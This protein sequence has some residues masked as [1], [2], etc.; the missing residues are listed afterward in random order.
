MTTDRPG[1]HAYRKTTT[2][3]R[4]VAGLAGA[5]AAAVAA[6][7]LAQFSFSFGGGGDKSSTPMIDLNKIFD[8]FGAVTL[9]EK[10]EIL[11]GNQLYGKLIDRNGG[12]Y[13][14]RRV[15]SATQRF[16][17]DL[18]K[19]T[20][21]PNLPWEITV[22]DD[23]TINAWALPGGKIA[24]NKGLLR[25]AADEAELAA[26]IS[27]EVGHAELAHGLGMMKTERFSAGFSEVAKGALA[28]ALKDSGGLDNNLVGMMS[29]V[30]MGMVQTGYS[31]EYE[32]EADRHILNVFEQTGHDPAKAANFFK[33]LL[34]VTPPN[35]E[36]T[37]SLFSTHPGTRERIDKIETAA[38]G[39]ASP[40]AA[41]H[42]QEFAAIKHTFPTRS[43]FRRDGGG[44][45]YT[46]AGK[47]AASQ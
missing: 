36:G 13:A 37:T 9:G 43:R 47:S 25:Y 26:V 34:Q 44:G 3:R 38:R 42:A 28:A 17:E 45:T 21:R 33:T 12:A 46:T 32:D 6:P 30:V 2:R 31:R 8:M 1:F 16:A 27:H 24:V 18:L 35:T 39:K 22:V 29:G 19:T 15:Q 11:L 23:N 41:P 10:D 4:V 5:A 40:A 20:K 7:A 14:N